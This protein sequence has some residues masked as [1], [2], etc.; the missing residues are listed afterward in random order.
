MMLKEVMI[1]SETLPQT[2]HCAMKIGELQFQM[3]ATMTDGSFLLLSSVDKRFA[4]QNSIS[5]SDKDGFG[6]LSTLFSEINNADKNGEI[7]FIFEKSLD[8]TRVRCLAMHSV[9][10]AFALCIDKNYLC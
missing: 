4:T 6:R 8:K 5:L 2:K 1:C 3:C 9:N 10:Q 7:P